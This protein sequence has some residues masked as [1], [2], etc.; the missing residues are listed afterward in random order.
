MPRL[1]AKSF[2]TPDSVREMPNGQDH[3]RHPRRRDD[4][5]LRVQPRLALVDRRRPGDGRR[6]PARSATSDT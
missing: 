5:V 1:Q 4:R 3:V 6:P 2:A